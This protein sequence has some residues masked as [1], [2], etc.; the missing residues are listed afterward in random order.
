VVSRSQRRRAIRFVIETSAISERKACALFRLA[1]SAYR[2]KSTRPADTK[3]EEQIREVALKHR[4]WGYRQIT[5]YIRL[6]WPEPLNFKRVYRLY[7]E[8]N[9]K[10]RRKRR[11]KRVRPEDRR[12]MKTP[13]TPNIRWSMDFVTDSLRGGRAFRVLNML[14]DCSRRCLRAIVDT[15]ISGKRVVRELDQLVAEVGTPEQIVLDNGP[16]FICQALAEWAEANNVELAFIEKGKPQQNAFIE[17]F[18][19]RF[20]DECLNEHLFQDILDAR[21]IIGEWQDHYN[22]ERP[23]SALGGIPPR[24][25]EEQILKQA[26]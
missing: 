23:H 1:R 10:L 25:F 9:L 3:L 20:R 24:I 17:S 12:P 5:R 13:I 6:T 18:N 2:R 21:A 19:G 14:D 8:I 11:K 26:A 4:R 22:N 15:S 16:E 7:R